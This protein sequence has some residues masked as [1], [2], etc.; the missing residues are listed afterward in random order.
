MLYSQYMPQIIG[1]PGTTVLTGEVLHTWTVTEYERHERPTAWYVI[2]LVMGVFLVGYGLFTNNFLFALIVVL[3]AIIVFLQAHQ[4]PHE[5]PFSVTDLGVVLNN[6]FYPYSELSDFYLIYNPPEIKTLFFEPES[7]LRP[8]LRV[9]LGEQ[10]PV[11][12]KFTLRQYLVEN[13]E[14]EVEPLSDQIA[15]QWK[16]H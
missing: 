14:K 9:N 1:R 5:I 3:F 8:R 2:M 10:D 4:E 7:S 13:V 15:R 11:E 6:R 12:L 16:I